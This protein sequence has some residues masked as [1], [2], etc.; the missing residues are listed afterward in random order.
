[1][2]DDTQRGHDAAEKVLAGVR[3]APRPVRMSDLVEWGMANGLTAF[4]IRAAV[5]ALTE[6]GG[7]LRVNA[8]D[9]IEVNPDTA[10]HR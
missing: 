7:P 10:D 4:N 1:M 6:Q 5:L 8:D 2:S 3:R 9:R